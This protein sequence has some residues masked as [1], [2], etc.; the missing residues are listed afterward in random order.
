MEYRDFVYWD[1]ERRG[2]S[3][4][5]A[6]PVV[7][8]VRD[9]VDYI[10]EH[11][12]GVVGVFRKTASSQDLEEYREI[13]NSGG[14]IDFDTTYGDVSKRVHL[15]ASILK[16]YIREMEEPLLTHKYSK[17]FL[18]VYESHDEHDKK[19]V[20]RIIEMLP[21][22]Q[23]LLVSY[24]TNLLVA[25]IKNEN[26]LLD[27]EAMT[28]LFTPLFFRTGSSN[29]LQVVTELR[30]MSDIVAI[31]LKHHK[32]IDMY[33]QRA[34]KELKPGFVPLVGKS[35]EFEV[36]ALE[37]YIPKEPSGLRFRE[38]DTILV[39]C[40]DDCGRWWFGKLNDNEGWFPSKYAVEQINANEYM[41]FIKQRKQAPTSHSEERD[42]SPST[43]KDSFHQNRSR[44]FVVGKKLDKEKK[45]S[46]EGSAKLPKKSKSSKLE[47]IKRIDIDK[48]ILTPR[49]KLKSKSTMHHDPPDIQTIHAQ[50]TEEKQRREQLETKFEKLLTKLNIKEE[51]L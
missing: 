3:N 10:K 2:W 1:M 23:L 25:L 26:N 11:G 16:M 14:T 42:E 4:F 27:L 36:V 49:T 50:I 38:G 47:G 39:T 33:A 37:D 32:T 31:L 51:D 13:Y 15:A 21:P 24:M 34:T 35:Y 6:C 9:M 18:S 45:K 43:K 19:E 28:T 29:V 5:S 7:Y 46:K 41:K 44:S 8:F 48:S 22:E 17:T 12:M 40:V 30:I 20:V